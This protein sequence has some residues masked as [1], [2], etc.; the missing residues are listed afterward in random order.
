MTSPQNLKSQCICLKNTPK[1][2]RKRKSKTTRIKSSL[3]STGS[4]TA[5]FL[6]LS[7][8]KTNSLLGS[9]PI[10]IKPLWLD[11]CPPPLHKHK[12]CQ[13]FRWPILLEGQWSISA[14]ILSIIFDIVGNSLLLSILS[15]FGFQEN[16]FL[17]FFWTFN[18][19]FPK[20]ITNCFSSPISTSLR[21][22]SSLV[23]LLTFI[24]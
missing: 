11:R 21:I 24:H 20:F 4:F 22:T 8:R 5:I 16:T 3:I 6:C 12:L 1:K 2:E 17:F 18:M 7:W 23:V 13:S 19:E 9:P 10:L 15:S 14:F